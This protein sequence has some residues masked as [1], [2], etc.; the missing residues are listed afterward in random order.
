VPTAVSD[1]EQGRIRVEALEAAL[2]AGSGPTIV[3][4]QA[5]NLHSGAFDLLGEAIECSHQH[6]AWV[7]VDGAF[8]LWAGAS[9][10]HRY[11]TVG[12]E[13]A[14]SWATDAHK[15]LNAPYDCGLAI[16]AEPTVLR[17]V[18]GAH[19]SYLTAT[20]PST[21]DP[22]EKTPEL[23]RRARGVPVYAALR[24]LGRSGVAAL[25]DCLV[26]NAQ[27]LAAGIAR[28]DGAQ[29]LNQVDYTQVCV[30]FGDDART[31]EVT[32]RLLA[33]GT[34]WMSG[35]RWKGRDVLRI[36]V[37]NWSTDDHDVRVSIDAVRRAATG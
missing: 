22:F 20:G 15:T 26:S 18:F 11:L 24:S 32:A 19:P 30:A 6:G 3:C 31:R 29:I 10:T 25:V 33:E 5:G 12:M 27:E 23:S 8:G 16:V 9:A 14:D 35:S 21:G 36:S 4:L 2:A 28:I 7:H 13:N 37:S 17:T 1:D 34:V